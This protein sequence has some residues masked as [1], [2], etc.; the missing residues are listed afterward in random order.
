MHG[1]SAAGLKELITGIKSS[2][3]IKAHLE[4]EL[5]YDFAMKISKMVKEPYAMMDTSDGLAD[6]L[7]KIAQAS[8][9]TINTDYDSIPH[10]N[11]V[12]EEQV[13]F[14]GEDYKLVAVIPQKYVQQI[15][16]AVLIGHAN[17]YNGTRL[18]I[19]GVR[20]NNYSELNIY[21]HFGEE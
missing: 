4:P 16:G 15:E 3:L 6:A 8:N 5:D 17:E 11:S 21:N 12:T 1:S 13:L 10:L 14:G 2:E 9:I 18:E 20:Y 19:S 7:F